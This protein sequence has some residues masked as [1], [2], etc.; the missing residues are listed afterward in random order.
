M[1]EYIENRP[2]SCSSCGHYPIFGRESS[3]PTHN[4]ILIECRWICD[5]CGVLVRV[6]EKVI[7]NNAETQK[8][9]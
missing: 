3:A 6:D 8:A 2:V 1:S 5:R 7:E 9:N 4:G